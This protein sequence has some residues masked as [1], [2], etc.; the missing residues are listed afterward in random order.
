MKRLLTLAVLISAALLAAP[1]VPIPGSSAVC[2][3]ECDDEKRCRL[4]LNCD[5]SCI[6]CEP[7]P[8]GR[9][10]TCFKRPN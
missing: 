10:G 8:D 3:T 1:A 4:D 9:K 2:T 6:R 5:I 7:D